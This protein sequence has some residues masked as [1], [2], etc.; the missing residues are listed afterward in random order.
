MPSRVR[1]PPWSRCS[2][3]QLCVWCEGDWGQPWTY[4]SGTCAKEHKFALAYPNTPIECM[5]P[6]TSLLP[7][8]CNGFVRTRNRSLLQRVFYSW[9]L[10]NHC[11]KCCA[12]LPDFSDCKSCRRGVI[13]PEQCTFCFGDTCQR[14]WNEAWEACSKCR[15]KW[16]LG[17][18]PPT[19]PDSAFMEEI[20]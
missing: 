12:P 9:Q 20:D 6:D 11:S 10:G 14:C 4:C 18:P 5:Y 13:V 8:E 19:T 16:R 2:S 15:E 17:I 3:L 7:W 1:S